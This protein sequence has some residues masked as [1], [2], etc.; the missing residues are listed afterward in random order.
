MYPDIDALMQ[1]ARRARESAY[2]PYSRFTVGAALLAEDG[3]IFEAANVENA[4]YGLAMCAERAAVF[5]AVSAGRRRFLAIAVAGPETAAC[6]P[7]GA[8]RQV[9]SE[10]NPEL[11]VAYTTGA[12]IARAT[13]TELLPAAFGPRSVEPAT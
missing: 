12:G 5:A 6:A 11:P 13:L 4:S 7:C 9:L 3:T 1:R 2:A 8:C 10:F